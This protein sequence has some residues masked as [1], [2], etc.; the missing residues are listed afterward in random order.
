MCTAG[1]PQQSLPD[2]SGSALESSSVLPEDVRKDAPKEVPEDC[3]SVTSTAFVPLAGP[4]HVRYIEERFDPAIGKW[5]SFPGYP[6]LVPIEEIENSG[7]TKTTNPIHD[8]AKGTHLTLNKRLP[9]LGM[10]DKIPTYTISINSPY[11]KKACRAVMGHIPWLMWDD[12][13][14]PVRSTCVPLQRQV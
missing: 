14:D 5:N 6:D 7:Y 12:P 2:K 3:L 11:L 1:S 4:P 13:V 8:V 10:G 9:D